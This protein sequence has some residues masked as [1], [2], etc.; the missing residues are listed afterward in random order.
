MIWQK[1]DYELPA[2]LW[3]LFIVLPLYI[4][5][6][7]PLTGTDTGAGGGDH[8]NENGTVPAFKLLV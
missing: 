6:T 5:L 4:R 2:L 7:L 8:N 3:L 1:G